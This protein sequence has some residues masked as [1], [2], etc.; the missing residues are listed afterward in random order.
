MIVMSISGK[1]F[2]NGLSNMFVFIELH[3]GCGLYE[4]VGTV[5]ANRFD[6][7]NRLNRDKDY[8]TKRKARE[9]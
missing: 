8:S 4:R 9:I 7:V 2:V 1:T 3:T 5:P 6:H